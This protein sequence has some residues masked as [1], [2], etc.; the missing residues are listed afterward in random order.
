MCEK[1]VPYPGDLTG[2]PGGF[3]D[4]VNSFMKDSGKIAILYSIELAVKNKDG[5]KNLT[6]SVKEALE[7]MYQTPWKKVVMSPDKKEVLNQS[8]RA[9]NSI[10]VEGQD[11]S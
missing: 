11:E 9:N 7:Y 8:I 1:T 3:N 6:E 4:I 5:G 2:F 10:T